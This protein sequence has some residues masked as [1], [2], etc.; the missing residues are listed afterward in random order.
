MNTDEKIFKAIEQQGK[1]LEALQT[2]QT[3]LN[4]TVT[5]LQADVTTI[6]TEERQQ[7]TLSP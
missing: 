1:A 5:A 6:K 4:E 7:R 3:Q 2:G